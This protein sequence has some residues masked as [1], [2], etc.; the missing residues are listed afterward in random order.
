MFHLTSRITYQCGTFLIIQNM[1]HLTDR[2]TSKPYPHVSV[3]Y[4]NNER[5]DCCLTGR[6]YIKGYEYEIT[7]VR[8]IKRFVI[9]LDERYYYGRTDICTFQNISKKAGLMSVIIS[10]AESGQRNF[11]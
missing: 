4:A 11:L 6:L 2:K 9:I 8:D 10:P 1:L 3:V 5:G 7:A